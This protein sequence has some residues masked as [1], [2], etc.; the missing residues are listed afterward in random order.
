MAF[1]SSIDRFG[2]ATAELVRSP[3]LTQ[4]MHV[5]TEIFDPMIVLVAACVIAGGFLIRHKR[6][7]AMRFA[8]SVIA[9][10]GFVWVTK[11]LV[12]HELPKGVGQMLFS[13]QNMR[14]L[15]Q[16]VINHTAKIV[17]RHPIRA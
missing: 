11:G 9:I 17:N 4:V 14:D 7:D 3:W 1:V 15:H 2:V 13:S 10:S 12:K 8:I 16:S 5:L 6:F